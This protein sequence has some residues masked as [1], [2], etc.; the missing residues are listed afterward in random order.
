MICPKCQTE[1]PEGSQ[2]CINCGAK[3][4]VSPVSPKPTAQ[5]TQ[6]TQAPQPE[7]PPPPPTKTVSKPWWETWWKILL[8]LLCIGPL[9]LIGTWLVWAKTNWSKAVKWLV[10]GIIVLIVLTA[11]IY[12]GVSLA[13]IKQPPKQPKIQP[14]EFQPYLPPTQKPELFPTPTSTIAPQPPTQ[15]PI[16]QTVGTEFAGVSAE[17]NEVTRSGNAVT[18]KFTLRASSNYKDLEKSFESYSSSSYTSIYGE[19]INCKT[20][21]INLRLCDKGPYSLETAYLVDEANQI[22]YEVLK[23]VDGKPLASKTEAKD[24]KVGQTMSLFAQFTAPPETTK[25]VTIN[26]PKIQPFTGV[27]LE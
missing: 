10:T 13:R 12:L 1:N 27:S 9:G 14:E 18:V 11:N 15:L 2:F 7:A 25:T 26:F 16:L 19:L 24:L 22:K 17:L 4:E 3:L 5:S 21:G 8:I 6:P 23:G 20:Y